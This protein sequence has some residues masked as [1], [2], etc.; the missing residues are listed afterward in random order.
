MKSSSYL[1][2][3]LAVLL[4]L[5]A[6]KTYAAV[7][8]PVDMNSNLVAIVAAV[9]FPGYVTT[10][11]VFVD[12]TAEHV[13]DL[14]CKLNSNTTLHSDNRTFVK[15]E[16]TGGVAGLTADITKKLYNMTNGIWLPGEFTR[17]DV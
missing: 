17:P 1:F 3:V 9:E 10:E 2:L 4:C 12:T 15:F 7:H 16:P 8:D 11:K 13:H 14:S 5:I 6:G